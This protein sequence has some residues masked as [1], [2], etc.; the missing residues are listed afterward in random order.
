M[1]ENKAGVWIPIPVGIGKPGQEGK[2]QIGQIRPKTTFPGSKDLTFF[3]VF[4]VKNDATISGTP[5]IEEQPKQSL[6]KDPGQE[7]QRGFENI[8]GYFT[9]INPNSEMYLTATGATTLEIQ[10]DIFMLILMK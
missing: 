5:V 3:Y 7:W 1:L 9:L 8:D 4:G 2:I 10:G 6:R